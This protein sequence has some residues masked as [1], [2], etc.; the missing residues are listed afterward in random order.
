MKT[1]LRPRILP[2]LT[3]SRSL[4][5]ANLNVRSF[6][7]SFKSRRLRRLG[8]VE[9]PSTYD[10]YDMLRTVEITDRQQY[11]SWVIY[12]LNR[13]LKALPCVSREQMK[14]FSEILQ[15]ITI[16]SMVV[17]IHAKR[18]RRASFNLHRSGRWAQQRGRGT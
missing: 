18:N 14:H 17:P 13:L 4:D 8:L 2:T 1:S 10:N 12:R 5:A 9:N 6:T 7:M 3:S 15:A 16:V 11:E